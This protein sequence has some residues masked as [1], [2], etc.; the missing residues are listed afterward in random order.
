MTDKEILKELK[1]LGTAQNRK[2][3]KRH[4]VGE[5]LY[6][7]SYANLNKLRKK[8]KID[9]ELA[10]KLWTTGNHDAQIL[11]TMIADPAL[12]NNRLLEA[13]AKDL[14]NYVL[15]DAFAGIVSQ[16]SFA[17]KKMEKWSKSKGEWIG[18]AGWLLLA[19]LTMKDEELSDDYFENYLEIIEKDIH[20]R[21]NQ[22]RDAMNSALI[23]IGIR[24]S[25]L[26]KKALSAAKKIGKVEV[27][28]GE[29]NCKTPDAGE[30]IRKARKRKR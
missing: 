14:S 26:E 3:Y 10:Q 5:K 30:Y 28:H 1:A 4:G 7:V 11:A 22:V 25:K 6:G 24:N 23:A 15:T 8:I 17:R 19:H 2:I 29:T 18:R 12:M 21:K 16:T 9:H 27:D 20:S 13:W